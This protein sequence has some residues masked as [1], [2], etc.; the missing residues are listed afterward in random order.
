MPV[1]RISV[2]RDLEF[3]RIVTNLM[4]RERYPANDI[5]EVYLHRWQIETMFQEV[6]EVFDL[7]RLIGTTPKAMLFQMA[8]C[9]LVYNVV[10]VVKHYVA[11]AGKLAKLIERF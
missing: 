5:L 11:E 8:L 3:L 2:E 10:R 4:D 6:T 1:R 9:M 7:R